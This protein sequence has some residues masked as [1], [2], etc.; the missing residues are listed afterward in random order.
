MTRIVDAAR[1][2]IGRDGRAPISEPSKSPIVAVN[3]APEIRMI[4]PFHAQ[5][6][7]SGARL[8]CDQATR[9]LR[10][11]VHR[12][13]QR[14]PQRERFRLLG[15][16]RAPSPTHH[17]HARHDQHQSNHPQQQSEGTL[18]RHNG[19]LPRRPRLNR[20]HPDRSGRR[21][22]TQRL[23]SANAPVGG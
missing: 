18:N 13:C 8:S 2:R 6:V 10:R 3:T 21:G 9:S 11:F 12:P 17:V 22:R 1:Q 19:P 16:G 4:R 14:A 15:E 20:G 23:L 7:E 5:S